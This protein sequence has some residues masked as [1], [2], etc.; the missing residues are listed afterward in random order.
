MRKGVLVWK[1]P[2]LR[3]TAC[4]ILVYFSCRVWCS[5]QNYINLL[6][7]DELKRAW[8]EVVSENAMLGAIFAEQL[9]FS[10]KANLANK[11]NQ[12]K[13]KQIKT[14][15]AGNNK[16][17]LTNIQGIQTVSVREIFSL[18]GT[19]TESPFGVGK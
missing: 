2:C 8:D 6:S 14:Y 13:A 17:A 4:A 16:N 11:I 19:A 18:S 5:A 9:L 10:L 3:L 15:A 12:R 7:D 1:T